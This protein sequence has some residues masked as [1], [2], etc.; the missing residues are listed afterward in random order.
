[1]LAASGA[2][3]DTVDTDDPIGLGRLTEDGQALAAAQ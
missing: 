1:V 2:G 3:Q